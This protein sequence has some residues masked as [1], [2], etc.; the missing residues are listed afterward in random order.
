MEAQRL[1]DAGEEVP[2]ASG[3]YVDCTEMCRY[4]ADGRCLSS[5]ELCGVRNSLRK[6]SWKELDDKIAGP[7]KRM[8]SFRG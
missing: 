1:D 4:L 5:K 3:C 2:E 8:K 7:A 6:S